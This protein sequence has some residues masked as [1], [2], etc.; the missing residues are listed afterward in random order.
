KEYKRQP[1]LDM[2][3]AAQAY[4]LGFTGKGVTVGILDSGIA[5][6]HPEFA[7]AIAGGFDFNTNTPYTNSQGVDSDNAPGHGTHVAGIIGARR[8]GVGMHG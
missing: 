4:A 7:G 8:D 3:N 6:N 1:G 5:G 2:I